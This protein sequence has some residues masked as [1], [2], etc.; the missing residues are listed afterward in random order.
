MVL[1]CY[2][3]PRRYS[4]TTTISVVVITVVVGVVVM[5]VVLLLL[6]WW[7]WRWPY[8]YINL[9]FHTSSS[10]QGLHSVKSWP[11]CILE[12]LWVA[13]LLC[14]KVQVNVN[15]ACVSLKANTLA[16]LMIAPCGQTDMHDHSY[17]YFYVHCTILPTFTDKHLNCSTQVPPVRKQCSNDTDK[18]CWVWRITDVKHIYFLL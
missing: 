8:C 17:I 5:V 12:L 14:P 11:E 10:S 9:V 18:R 16:L 6:Q 7:R 15:L 13:D 4:D 2:S 3:L 1:P